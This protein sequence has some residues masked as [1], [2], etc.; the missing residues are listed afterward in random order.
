MCPYIATYLSRKS[1]YF[2]H[3]FW[4]N[5]FSPRR[6]L[7][8]DVLRLKPFLVWLCL[9]WVSPQNGYCKIGKIWENQDLAVD[10]EASYFHFP[11]RFPT[12]LETPRELRAFNPRSRSKIQLAW[13]SRPTNSTWH[14]P[15]WSRSL[16]W[17][18]RKWDIQNVQTIYP[19]SVIRTWRNL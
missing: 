2:N 8:N 9:K 11:K 12:S 3:P 15:R 7:W 19:K 5:P 17:T 16:A 18:L 10:F 14:G 1:Q 13:S 6:R 4:V